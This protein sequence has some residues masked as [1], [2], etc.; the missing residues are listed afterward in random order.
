MR[1]ENRTYIGRKENPI[2]VVQS[3][4][5]TSTPI[6][7]KFGNVGGTHA[8]TLKFLVGLP[9]IFPAEDFSNCQE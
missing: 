1:K 5:G 8:P 9:I 4:L 7:V 2:N 6:N 3:D